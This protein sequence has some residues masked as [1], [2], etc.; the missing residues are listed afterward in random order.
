MTW[1]KVTWLVIFIGLGCSKLENPQSNFVAGPVPGCESV[2]ANPYDVAA[3]QQTVSFLAAPDMAGRSPGTAGDATARS[4]I[5][6]RFGCI[7]L[8]PALSGFQQPFINDAGDQTA[9]VIGVIPG[10]D[11]SLSNDIIVVGAH[12]DHLG[13]EAGQIYPGANDNAS[14]IA[15]LL[16]AAQGLKARPTPPR[17]TVVF[18]AFGS[19]ELGEAGA[20]RYVANA[21]ANLPMARVVHMVNLDMVGSYTHENKVYAAGI[22]T[23]QFAQ[24]YLVARIASR[25]GF[26]VELDTGVYGDDNR[27]FCEAGVPYTYFHMDDD[28]CFHKP[29]DTAE[30]L[31]Y[32]HM[33][34]VAQLTQELTGDLADSNDDLAVARAVTGCTDVGQF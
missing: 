15:A 9:N 16:A 34:L 22:A 18:A 12:H 32:Q 4:F 14:G 23:S 29:C 17:R 28:L 31:D 10:T 2:P 30:L 25:P 19:E 6:T 8:S 1:L 24:G 3:L 21:P 5:E 20:E 26:N 11:P 13:V 27:P 7:G 33:A